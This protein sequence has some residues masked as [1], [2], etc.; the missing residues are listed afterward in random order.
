MADFKIVRPVDAAICTWN[1]F[2]HL[3]TEQ[4]ARRHLHRV[5]ECLRPGGIYVLGFHLLPPDVSDECVERWSARHGHIRLTVT[6]RV[7]STNHRRRIEHLRVNLCV[8]STRRIA[9][10]RSEFPL[11]RYNARQFMRLLKTVPELALLDVYDFW[12]DI[13]KP[14]KLDNH[15]TDTVFIL[16][17]R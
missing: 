2:R 14:L 11:R 12:Y 17:R 13:D 4:A 3:T 5:A 15:I 8:R 10:L 6:L 7:L 1:T 16:G 9:R